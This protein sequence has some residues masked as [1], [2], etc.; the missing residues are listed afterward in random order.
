[1]LGVRLA[2]LVRSRRAQFAASLEEFA[3]F[4]LRDTA[5]VAT[6]EKL[7]LMLLWGEMEEE[8]E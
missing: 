2:G 8:D 6:E 4:V 3:W 1:M 7:P 5:R